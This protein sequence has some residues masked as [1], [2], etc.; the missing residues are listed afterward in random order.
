MNEDNKD[1]VMELTIDVLLRQGWQVFIMEA[2]Q[3]YCAK[4]PAPRD[5]V[6]DT[7][8]DEKGNHIYHGERGVL[9]YL[10]I[11]NRIPHIAKDLNTAWSL[12]DDG[13]RTNFDDNNWTEWWA[14]LA[15]C[16]SEQAAGAICRRWLQRQ[17][18]NDNRK[19]KS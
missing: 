19:A 15:Y 14:V 12:L 10:V 11:C 7:P 3:I 9:E 1:P 5:V 16:D 18:W 8:L 17:N 13:V 6:F 4:A 2:P